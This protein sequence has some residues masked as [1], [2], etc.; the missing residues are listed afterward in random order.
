MGVFSC[1]PPM[2]ATE[3]TFLAIKPD[4]VQRNLVGEIIGR[5]EKRGYQ[6]VGVKFMQVPKELAEEH[7][8][9]H[10]GRPFF[11][12]LIDFIT[13]GPVVA[14]VWQGTN[15]VA[16]ART[17]IGATSPSASA[18]GTIRG[19]FGLVVGRNIIHGSGAV[20]TAEREINLWFKEGELSSW[21]ANRNGD[22]YE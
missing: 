19:D 2:P 8:A 17:M 21:T 12:G 10:K 4:G 22:I 15:V 13:S 18:P 5:F 16:G 1:C 11:Q 20:E 14:M 9:E 7:Y 6:L 3:R